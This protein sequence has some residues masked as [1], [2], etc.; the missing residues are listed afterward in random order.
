MVIKEATVWGTWL[1]GLGLETVPQG[2]AAH[3]R[4]RSYSTPAE[5]CQNRA[6]ER[7]ICWQGAHTSVYLNV[8]V[9]I[10]CQYSLISPGLTVTSSFGSQTWAHSGGGSRVHFFVPF[11]WACHDGFPTAS[12]CRWKTGRSNFFYPDFYWT[13]A[14][15]I[16]NL[17][18]NVFDNAFCKFCL[19]DWLKYRL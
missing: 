6:N 19:F 2:H 15:G 3:A 10:R 12:I 9:Y 5:S 13:K 8:H 4:Q 16:R 17:S 14:F 18:K 7:L 11:I 1:L